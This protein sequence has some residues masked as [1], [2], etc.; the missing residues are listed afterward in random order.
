MNFYT[1]PWEHIVIDDFLPENQ[2]QQFCKQAENFEPRNDES[3]VD[4]YYLDYDPFN[5]EHFIQKFSNPKR[6]SG[7]FSK[8][9]HFASMRKPFEHAIHTDAD[10]KIMTAVL[11][12]APEKSIGTRLFNSLQEPVK[13]IEWKPN[14]LLIFCSNNNT[15]H[16]FMSIGIRHTLNYFLVDTNIHIKMEEYRNSVIRS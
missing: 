5:I 3:G 6:N 4:R 15:W 10:F 12:L 14:R 8:L 9:I 2:F 11:Y 7:N 13:T 1:D 16:D